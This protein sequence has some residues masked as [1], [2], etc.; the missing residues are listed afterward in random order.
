MA[1][2]VI[3]EIKDRLNIVEVVGSYIQ[4]KQA[5][6][7]WKANCPF[8]NEKTASFNVNPS[9]QIWHCFGC[10]EGGDVFSF[11]QKHEHLD[12]VET[13]KLLADRAGVTLP[14]R[15]P[16]DAG[17]KDQKDRLFRVN[18]FAAKFYNSVLLGPDGAAAREYLKRRGVADATV[19]T[20]QI[21]YAPEGY[22]VL[23]KP[24]LA[25]GARREDLV[26]AG[27]S[28]QGERGTYDR[29]R[30]RITFPIFNQQGQVVGFSARILVDDGKSAKYINSPESPIYHKGS[31]IFGLNFA[32]NA[33]I[34]S[35]EVVV[36][37]GQ[38][39][40]IK[41]QQTG[42]LNTVATS[43]TAFT[44]DHLRI[45]KRYASTIL[46]AFDQDEAGQ[47]ALYKSGQMALRLGFS[48]RV[49]RYVGAKDPDELIT[50]NPALWEEAVKKAVWFVD[51]F[52]QRAEAEFPARSLEQRKFIS[53]SV[54]PLIG[55]L[56]DSLERDYFIKKLEEEFGMDGKTVRAAIQSAGT[57]G[58]PVGVIQSIEVY[59]ESREPV[60]AV[61]KN[62]LGA[63][64]HK[65]FRE[66]F[67]KEGA[68]EDFIHPDSRELAG[69]LLRAEPVPD[70]LQS[71]AQEAE[72]MVESQSQN[73]GEMVNSFTDLQK[74]FYT[75]RLLSLRTALLNITPLMRQAERSGN[76][77]A[78]RELQQQFAHVS[79][80]RLELERK[81]QDL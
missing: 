36:V 27:V 51:F 15:R 18:N 8:H 20:W 71:L 81:I 79:A 80:T 58:A 68:I 12:F 6:V 23:E 37:E 7:N 22:Q 39:D 59:D 55:L 60:S 9:R 48:V 34:Q 28:V 5:G 50:K 31:T 32:R 33:I 75:F 1:D 17:F 38:M 21:G 40:C 16:E 77:D 74:T 69:Y 72:F 43:G 13:L 78:L 29:F 2:G 42:F 76:M 46:F 70:R 49:I 44:E 45:L 10:N 11:V 47:K 14:D 4:L 35:G 65:Q 63:L 24:L 73:D 57:S 54:V 30:G 53:T 41:P 26:A 62:I 64:A 61:E 56:V 52:L 66:L 25:K 67:V 3:Q 19:T